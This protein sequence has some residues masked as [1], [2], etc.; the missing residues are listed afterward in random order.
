M[1]IDHVAHR[2]ENPQETH[3]FYTTVLG[4]KLVQA[5]ASKEL[6]LVYALSEEGNLVFTASGG[7]HTSDDAP[8]WEHQHVGLTLETRAEFDGWLRRFR[9]CGIRHKLVDN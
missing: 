4:L 7:M 6:M 3:K 5:Y 1:R 9:Q 2:C 8:D